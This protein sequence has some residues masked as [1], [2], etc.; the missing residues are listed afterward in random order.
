MISGLR[1][2]IIAY[3]IKVSRTRQMPPKEIQHMRAKAAIMAMA[4]LEINTGSAPL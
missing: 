4:L 2:A 1:I 3:G